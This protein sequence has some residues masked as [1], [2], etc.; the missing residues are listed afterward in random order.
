MHSLIANCKLVLIESLKSL[1]GP[2]TIAWLKDQSSFL[3][4]YLQSYVIPFS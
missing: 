4:F 2:E 3:I 1:G